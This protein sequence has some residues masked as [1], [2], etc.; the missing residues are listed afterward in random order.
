MGIFPWQ[1]SRMNCI[2]LPFYTI[3][4]GVYIR[5]REPVPS[6]SPRRRT[7]LQL[8]RQALRV[9][10]QLRIRIRNP[11]PLQQTVWTILRRVWKRLSGNVHPPPNSCN[12]WT[13]NCCNDW[14][15]ILDLRPADSSFVFVVN[16]G[17][18]HYR[19]NCIQLIYWELVER[20]HNKPVRLITFRL[21][22]RTTL[23]EFITSQ[24]G[25]LHSD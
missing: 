8:I 15:L 20:I 16:E 5:G 11:T 24:S 6:D 19:Y 12:N 1:V 7:K 13:L 14:T 9:D 21:E 22:E 17:L 10:H 25:S 23:L 3:P 2:S 18:H 4:A